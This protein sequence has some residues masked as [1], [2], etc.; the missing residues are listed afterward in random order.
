MTPH[1]VVYSWDST[2]Q[3]YNVVCIGDPDFGEQFHPGEG[4][5]L[6]VIEDSVIV[7]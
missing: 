6:Y 2:L 3:V 4:Y 5:W 1:M 7:P